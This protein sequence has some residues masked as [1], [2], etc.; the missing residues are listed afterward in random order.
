MACTY[1]K[2]FLTG[3]P[4]T[5]VSFPLLRLW[6][7]PDLNIV[8]RIG[9]APSGKP[10]RTDIIRGYQRIKDLLTN[11]YVYHYKE[12]LEEEAE[13]GS[14]VPGALRRGGCSP[15]SIPASSPSPGSEGRNR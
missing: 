7:D 14:R 13:E 2:V 11:E 9:Y 4:G 10:L 8:K 6:V 5:E 12:V 15:R 1:C 3:K